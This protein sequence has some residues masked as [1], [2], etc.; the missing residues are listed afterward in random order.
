[1]TSNFCVIHSSDGALE[2]MEEAVNQDTY[3]IRLTPRSIPILQ[4]EFNEVARGL[5]E[6]CA[7]GASIGGKTA[8]EKFK[9]IYPDLS[10]LTKEV[11]E[12]IENVH[13]VQKVISDFIEKLNVIKAKAGVDRLKPLID[14][15]KS[16]I[17]AVAHCAFDFTNGDLWINQR[18]YSHIMRAAYGTSMITE[19]MVGIDGSILTLDRNPTLAVENECR[20]HPDFGNLCRITAEFISGFLEIKPIIDR[21]SATERLTRV[22]PVVIDASE[23]KEKEKD[24]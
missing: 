24:K 22:A 8:L 4:K 17:L 13:L 11:R 16:L 1:M 2:I 15:R 7:Y 14:G 18:L 3:H 5:Y 10:S 6:D 9:Q 21:L 20:D 19:A 23:K 12:Y